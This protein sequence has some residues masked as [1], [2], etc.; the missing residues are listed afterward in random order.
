M[1]NA[2]GSANKPTDSALANPQSAICNPQSPDS[3]ICNPQSVRRRAAI[4]V[5]P[6]SGQARARRRA[7]KLLYR[8]ARAGVAVT[9]S[10]T[11]GPEDGRALAA[12][13]AGETDM[14]VSV[15]GDGTLNQVM[16][17]ILDAGLQTP[18]LVVS[19]GT[20]NVV[21]SELGLLKRLPALVEIALHG[22]ARPLD[23]G[24]VFKPGASEPKRFILCAGAGFDA[25]VVAGL[26]SVR[27]AA[28]ITR[29]SYAPPII[30]AFLNYRFPPMRVTVDGR[31]AQSGAIL[32]VVANMSRYGGNFKICPQ[33]QPD[34][35]RL[36]ICCLR[37]RGFLALLRFAWG[38][39]RGTLTQ[40]PGV[41]FYQGRVVEVE[42]DAPVPVQVDGDSSGELPLRFE[43]QPKAVNF[44]CA[45]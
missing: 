13:I 2:E 15:G 32:T 21:A 17:G 3:A 31:L 10:E 8:L 29:W 42:A 18:I 44:L 34:D 24:V 22:L 37:N 43:V 41:S 23:V 19:T 25:A 30:R 39:A 14:V 28:G 11:A 4:I 5:N 33:A 6:V 26:G 16:N 38:L 7:R 20:A 1:R 35:G 27:T 45:E 40:T 36:D 12:R 9:L